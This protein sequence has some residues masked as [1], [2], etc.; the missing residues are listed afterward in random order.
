[1]SDFKGLKV[2]Q[3]KRKS[4]ARVLA[5][6]LNTVVINRN[7]LECKWILSCF[8]P[9]FGLGDPGSERP[10]SRGDKNGFARPLSKLRR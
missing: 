9:S 1:M 8:Y 5:E 6:N 2:I 7:D 10:I 4:I 3:S